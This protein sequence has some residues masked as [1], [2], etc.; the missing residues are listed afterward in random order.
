[1][2]LFITLLA[3]LFLF[4]ACK[5]KPAEAADS[6]G[7]KSEHNY[8]VQN[9][10][11]GLNVRTYYRSD[12]Q[13]IEPSYTLGKKWYGMTAAVRIAEEGGAREYRP[14]LDHQI[15]NWSPEDTINSDGTTSK[16]NTQFWVGHRIEFRNYENESTN[17]YWRYRAI[18]KVDIGLTERYSIWGQTEPRWTFGQGQVD[19]TKIDDIR[20]QAGIKIN[21]DDNISFSPYIEVIADKDMKQ[22]SMMV[23]TA[24][25]INF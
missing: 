14:K 6:R 8:N 16:S 25:S 2:K 18:V 23:A 24:L 9:G 19:D 3:T 5:E 17:D 1:M 15:I 10:D 21:L 12:Y 22:E 20:N 7:T 11:Y 4:T 13:H